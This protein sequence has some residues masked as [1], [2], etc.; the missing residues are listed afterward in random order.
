MRLAGFLIVFSTCFPLLLSAQHAFK[1]DTLSALP[2]AE[3]DTVQPGVAGPFVGVHRDVLIVAGGANFPEG[4]PWNPLPDGRNPPKVYHDTIYFME[5]RSEFGPTEDG[6][7]PEWRQSSAVLPQACAYGVS[8]P[9]DKGLYCIAGE[10]KDGRDG[11][12]QLFHRHE[13]SFLLSY[14]KEKG[15]VVVSDGI[16]P[17]LPFGLTGAT[18]GM[19]DKTIYLAGGDDGGKA[20]MRFMSYT[21]GGPPKWSQIDDLWDGPART[22]AVGVVQDG[23]F[24]LFS[25]RRPHSG[26][27]E[28]LS[29]AHC[30]KPGRTLEKRSAYQVQDSNWT[31]LPPVTVDG[32]LRCVMAGTAA[33]FGTSSIHVYGGADG[34][35]FEAITKAAE[36]HALALNPA[37][38]ATLLAELN[39]LRDREHAGFSRDV[40]SFHTITKTWGKAGEMPAAPVTTTAVRWGDDVIIPSGETRPGVRSPAVYRG[41]PPARKSFGTLNYAALFGYLA[42]VLLNGLWFARRMKNTDDFFKAGGRIPWW[43]AG[44]SIF[45]TQL[46]AITFIAIPA[47]IFATNWTRFIGQVTIVAV[48]PL[49]IFFFLPFYRR[50]N[51]TTAYEYLELRFNRLVRK[52]GSALFIILQFNRIAVVLFLP[53]VA[54]SVATGL[55]IFLCILLMGLLCIIYTSLGGM[56]AVIWTDVVQVV[57]LLGGALL[58]LILMPM[59]YEGGINAMFDSAFAQDKMKMFDF[60]P[61]LS[62]ATFFALFLGG[63]AGNIISYGTDQ[64]V[65]QRYLTTRDRAAAARSIWTNAALVIPVSIVFFLI[66]TFLFLFYQTNPGAYDPT[67]SERNG[68]FP[69][70]IVNHLPAGVAGLVIA[71][72]FAASMSSLDSSMNSV[73]AAVTT[74]FVR[75]SNPDISQKSALRIARLVVIIIGL[76]GTGFALWMATSNIRDLWNLF[77]KVIGLFGGGL[78]GIFVLGMFTRRAT[79]GGILCGLLASLLVQAA[80]TYLPMFD[81]ALHAWMFAFTGLASCVI[82]GY[83]CSFFLPE[84]DT[85]RERGPTIHDLRKA[86]RGS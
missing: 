24:Y 72:V 59:N 2:P 44:L 76:L 55:D 80:L 53:A 84:R 11:R 57:V 79:T 65:I 4:L 35:Q 49:V 54:L 23:A 26:G 28:F 8:I 14:D 70:Y 63:F 6:P 19:I 83:L 30:Y 9:T 31:V 3:G 75:T 33:A 85:G 46:S 16:I 60:T 32:E 48:A 40:L 64:S 47:G 27:T 74:D 81:G 34:R 61:S 42:L 50:L 10:W 13:G 37:E 1:W 17:D 86:A 82:V 7:V 18:G 66:G 43:A 5:T 38:S 68:L 41:T 51:L 73:S 12:G 20:S 67:L 71:A 39:R 52:L 36:R 25:G 29:D 77:M 78:A 69:L 15:D 62:E 56:E 58:A 22:L 21:F 45:G